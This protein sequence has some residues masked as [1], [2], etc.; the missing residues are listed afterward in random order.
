MYVLATAAATTTANTFWGNYLSVTLV[1][2]GAGPQ[3]QRGANWFTYTGAGTPPTGSF[4]NELDGDM[5]VRTSDSEVF[6][7]AGGVWAD[8]GYK[9][10]QGIAA[11]TTACRMHRQAALTMGS[12][13]TKIPMDTVDFDSAGIGSVAQGGIVVKASGYYQVNGATLINSSATGT[14]TTC[15]IGIYKNDVQ[16]S[17]VYWQPAIQTYDSL[18]ISDVVYCVAGDVLTLYGIDS[19]GTALWNGAQGN[20]LSAVLITA[21][22]G[23][24]G[25]AGPTGAASTVPGPT[26]ATGPA[27]CSS[28]TGAWPYPP[29]VIT[30]SKHRRALPILLP[31][32]HLS[33]LP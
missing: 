27:G 6:K 5:A 24:Q 13:W 29:P 7:R 31:P 20:Y 10:S 4:L 33:G 32:V 11:S 26:G 19:Q 17:Q 15:S 30:P 23:P 14:Y 9:V 1:T 16:Q 8:Q 2:A 21:G 12:G 22:P 3:G 18:A 25:P 28:A